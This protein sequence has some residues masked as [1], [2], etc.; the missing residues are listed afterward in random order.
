MWRAQ[1]LELAQ[2][3]G[4][5]PEELVEWWAERAAIRELDGG[6]AREVAERD[7]FEELRGEVDVTSLASD[8]RSGPQSAGLDAAALARCAKPR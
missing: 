3:V 4:R 6:Q 5:D 8:R 2:R 1:C 7:A